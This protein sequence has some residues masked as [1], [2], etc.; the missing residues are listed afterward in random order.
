MSFVLS[1]APL[2][3][4]LFWHF[5]FRLTC[6]SSHCM[7]F[8]C[9]TCASYNAEQRADRESGKMLDLAHT[10]THTPLSITISDR[11]FHTHKTVMIASLLLRC[12]LFSWH[13]W[14]CEALS[15]SGFLLLTEASY[16][17][18]QNCSSA[19]NTHYDL[20]CVASYQPSPSYFY[21]TGKTRASMPT[22][23]WCEITQNTV[24]RLDSSPRQNSHMHCQPRGRAPPGIQRNFSNHTWSKD[25]IAVWNKGVTRMAYSPRLWLM[26]IGW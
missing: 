16:T 3:F 23:H 1:F 10:H 13:F 15:A 26:A 8:Q 17:H 7:H 5:W 25:I 21:P 9:Q 2:H 20:R 24:P 14:F 22:G 12:T 4:V 19:C 6:A 11:S 18:V